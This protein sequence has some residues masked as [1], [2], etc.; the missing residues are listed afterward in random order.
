MIKIL[1]RIISNLL[2]LP[3][4]NILPIIIIHILS[5]KYFEPTLLYSL[6]VIIPLNTGCSYMIYNALSKEKVSIKGMLDGYKFCKK[7]RIVFVITY[8]IKEI[9]LWLLMSNTIAINNNTQSFLV[10]LNSTI[11][12]I[13]TY[14]VSFMRYYSME[15][16]C[17]KEE[18]L[19]LI[20]TVKGSLYT[21]KHTTFIYINIKMLFMVIGIAIYYILPNKSFV[22]LEIFTFI[23]LVFAQI[24]DELIRISI[25]QIKKEDQKI[26]FFIC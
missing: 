6:L 22:N 17:G 15:G 20:D 21:S 12:Y 5:T 4:L 13:V 23:Y 11:F 1:R 18:K 14:K 16:F 10:W 25:Y 3:I 8:T 26:L 2:K 19:N 9:I 24:I 7:T